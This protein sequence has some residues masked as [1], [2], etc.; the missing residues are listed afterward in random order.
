[1]N[2]A[3]FGLKNHRFVS[4]T[5]SFDEWVCAVLTLHKDANFIQLQ[6]GGFKAY[7]EEFGYVGRYKSGEPDHATI[8][9][10]RFGEKEPAYA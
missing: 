3:G 10:V 8:W 2:S 1:M 4:D 7:T 9:S 6:D 5:A